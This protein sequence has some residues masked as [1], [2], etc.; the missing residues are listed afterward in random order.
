MVKKRI[1]INYDNLPAGVLQEIEKQYPEGWA[2]HVMKIPGAKDN[3][4]Y[5]I[6]VDTA[7]ISY[8]VKVKVK[9]DRKGIDAEEDF[10]PDFEEISGPDIPDSSSDEPFA[11]HAEE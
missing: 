10:L 11:E 4:F 6:L 1:I 8:L 5:A 9:K 7:D 3:F 2:N